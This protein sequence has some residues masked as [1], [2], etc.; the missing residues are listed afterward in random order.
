M[1]RP[2]YGSTH[3]R[4][5]MK[6]IALNTCASSQGYSVTYS[7]PV[8]L[9]II[10]SLAPFAVR[11]SQ[12]PN[13]RTARRS[14]LFSIDGAVPSSNGRLLTRT[15]ANGCSPLNHQPAIIKSKNQ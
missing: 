9:I 13:E 10:G 2:E 3:R 15:D 11:E 4:G 5:A 1:S 14:R 6:A 7:G 12:W 8:F